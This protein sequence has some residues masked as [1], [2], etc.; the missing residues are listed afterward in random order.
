M[1]E[2]I[3]W[4]DEHNSIHYGAAD[5]YAEER[6]ERLDEHMEGEHIGFV[7]P[8]CPGCEKGYDAKCDGCGRPMI[9]SEC[10]ERNDHACSYCD[11][12]AY[13]HLCEVGP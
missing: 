6:A 9:E 3:D 10:E 7:S 12:W 13:L 8:S 11:G 1:Q 5:N 2:P 4:T